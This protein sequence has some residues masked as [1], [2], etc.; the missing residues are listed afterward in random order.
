MSSW[1]DHAREEKTQQVKEFSLTTVCSHE[2][3]FV[4][5]LPK[6]SSTPPPRLKYWRQY[7]CLQSNIATTPSKH[8]PDR[9]RGSHLC[10]R[11]DPPTEDF[12][13]CNS[14]FVKTVTAYCN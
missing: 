13:E 6:A 2:V 9:G 3:N 4:V 5:T 14:K 1:H 11:H 8:F 7:L 12:F 10:T